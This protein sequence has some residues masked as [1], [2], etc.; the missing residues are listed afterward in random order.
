MFA[1]QDPKLEAEISQRV[2]TRKKKGAVKCAHLLSQQHSNQIT[3]QRAG[4]TTLSCFSLA[5]YYST[6]VPS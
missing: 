5:C 3:E 6:I 2:I 1:F 4:L